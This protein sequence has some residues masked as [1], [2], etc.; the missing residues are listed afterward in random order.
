M[1]RFDCLLIGVIAG[2]SASLFLPFAAPAKP[3]PVR[4]YTV[5]PV[6][7]AHCPASPLDDLNRRLRTYDV[8]TH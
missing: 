6:P 8:R 2:A 1:S 7:L 5:A 4:V 3:A